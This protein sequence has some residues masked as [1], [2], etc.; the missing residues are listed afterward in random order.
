MARVMNCRYNF[1]LYTG[2]VLAV[3]EREAMAWIRGI[4]RGLTTL[5]KEDEEMLG[6]V[7]AIGILFLGGQVIITLTTN[8]Q[9]HLMQISGRFSVLVVDHSAGKASR[10]RMCDRAEG[11][12]RGKARRQ[13]EQHGTKGSN[14]T[15]VRSLGP[16]EL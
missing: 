13:G 3:S 5:L 11:P 10:H 6:L 1:S 14:N 12:D 4:L 9:T 8:S 7:V 2:K 16:V 15:K